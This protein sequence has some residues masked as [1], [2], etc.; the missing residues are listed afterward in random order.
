MKFPW[1]RF[2]HAAPDRSRAAAVLA[3]GLVLLLS[4]GLRLELI[5]RSMP[6]PQHVDETY[7]ADN[8]ANMLRT[9]DFNPHFFM[10]GG[11]PIY[12][13]AGA[14]T[15]GYVD[16]ARHSELRSTAEI[17]SVN[18]PYYQHPRIVRPARLLFAVI[19]VVGLL[20]LALVAY[21][22]AGLPAMV[23]APAW[24][25]LSSLYFEQ[26][27][28]Y[29]NVNIVGCALTWA[30]IL[31]VLRHEAEPGLT[32][33]VWLPGLLSGMVIA[34]KYNFFPIV[35][36]P[37]LAI[38][39]YGERRRKEKALALLVVTAAAFLFCAPYTLLDFKGFLDD[40]GRITYDYSHG[41]FFSKPESATL[42][43]HLRLNLAEVGHELGAVS[44]LFVLIGAFVYGRKQPRR[45][46]I[47]AAAPLALLL[48]SSSMPTHF[49][50]N[51]LPFFPLWALLG[52]LGLVAATR[53][54]AELGERNSRT[55]SWPEGARFAAAAMLLLL[56]CGYFL[57]FEAPLNWLSTPLRSRQEAT[58]W[59]LRE[60]PKETPLLVA[61][62]LG[63]HPG[64][65]EQAG[66]RLETIELRSL[67]PIAFEAKL[68]KFPGALILLPHMNAYHW[69]ADLVTIGEKILPKITGFHQQIE[70]L[71]SFGKT[72]VSVCFDFPTG[73]S[74]EFVIGKSRRSAA[75]LAGLAQGRFLF[76]RDF[77]G[78]MT[79]VQPTGLAILAQALVSSPPLD[80]EAG[81][82]RVGIDAIGTPAKG[83]FP[84]VRVKLGELDLG[85]FVAGETPDTASFDFEL[86]EPRK[87]SLTLELL[88]D[89][90][91]RD[92]KGQIIADRNVFLQGVFL[93]PL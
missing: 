66:Y 69:N 83:R 2:L 75:E 28:A 23:A 8:A 16:A 14:M 58:E 48:Q 27:Q 26:S 82:Y 5:D 22:L 9:G 7:L 24:L 4:F 32:A 78:A 79:Q 56:A 30:V 45:I 74:P 44:F 31:W 10:Y 91:E 84:V 59:I 47:I 38:Y 19:S 93:H 89:E 76:G 13:T 40:L 88:N 20:L 92:A 68:A 62:E 3:L 70:V 18:Y 67:S 57:P 80:L 43:G 90:I 41:N 64:P 72:K 60:V 55:K 49:L 29:L 36:T 1:P 87:A 50:R 61:A 73:G 11:L 34:C 25:A 63:L 6:Y 52:A 71:Q 21:H 51:L 39:W 53:V 85:Q 86:K 81:Q 77:Q 17:G 37:L 65:L 33:K 42:W 35:L 46:L 54:L 12:L 15:L